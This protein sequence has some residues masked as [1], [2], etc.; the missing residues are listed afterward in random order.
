[1][2]L[3]TLG[4]LAGITDCFHS[5]YLVLHLWIPICWSILWCWKFS[6]GTGNFVVPL[7]I[8]NYH[9]HSIYNF[10][11]CDSNFF[12]LLPLW[13]LLCHLVISSQVSQWLCSPDLQ[14]HLPTPRW[15]VAACRR[16]PGL[17]GPAVSPRA[18]ESGHQR[19]QAA[20][21]SLGRV[22]QYDAMGETCR[23]KHSDNDM[24]MTTFVYR[25]GVCV[26]IYI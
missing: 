26:Y 18:A 25:K 17:H 19:A 24:S 12:V 13:D 16:C 21:A 4:S 3:A 6:T 9:F 5:V 1:M 8:F 20:N 22:G 23:R 2:F 14:C 11:L 7:P 15:K 10:G